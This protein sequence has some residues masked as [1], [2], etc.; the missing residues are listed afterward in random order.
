MKPQWNT[1]TYLIELSAAIALYAGLLV[2]S[3]LLERRLDPQGFVL[4]MINVMPIAGILAAAWAIVRGFGRMDELQRRIQFDA[5]VLAFAGTAVMSFSW[6]FLEDVGVPQLRA[7]M[8]WPMMAAL[9]IVGLI[10]AT[11]RYAR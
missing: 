6:G 2:A 9:W 11:R 3:N 8:V 5:L 10:V 1:R 4:V 7:F